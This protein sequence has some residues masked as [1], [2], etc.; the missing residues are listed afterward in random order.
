[1]SKFKSD[2]KSYCRYKNNS[3][4]SEYHYGFIIGEAFLQH[5]SEIGAVCLIA[6]T[7]FDS[8][9]T[10]ILHT[11][12][13]FNIWIA[14]MEKKYP[15]IL[16]VSHTVDSLSA[17][18]QVYCR[19]MGK[20][21][22]EIIE[23]SPDNG[24]MTFTEFESFLARDAARLEVLKDIYYPC[25]VAGQQLRIPS[26]ANS[27]RT[28]KVEIVSRM[29]EPEVLKAFKINGDFAVICKGLDADNGPS[30]SGAKLRDIVKTKLKE[31]KKL[32]KLSKDATEEELEVIKADLANLEIIY[33]ATPIL[34]PN[35][36][37]NYYVF[38]SEQII[39]SITTK[40]VSLI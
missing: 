1:M 12:K 4:D 16:L 5:N 10:N 39:N 26:A 29:S 14:G 28:C 19:M 17:S 23:V 32:L 38:H 35:E 31:A 11:F 27:T 36:D 24:E 7:T 40:E 6:G 13:E 20:N 18:A 9:S 3:G 21:L 34:F 33:K 37:D 30:E 15:E 8:N 2:L 25:L 22:I